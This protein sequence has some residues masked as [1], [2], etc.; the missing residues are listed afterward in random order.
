[1][2]NEQIIWFT[3]VKGGEVMKSGQVVRETEKAVQVHS[4]VYTVL[5]SGMSNSTGSKFST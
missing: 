3:A 1:M 5:Y 4:E 2:S